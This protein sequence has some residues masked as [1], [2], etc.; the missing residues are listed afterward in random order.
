MELFKL[1]DTAFVLHNGKI[2]ESTIKKIK[3]EELYVGESDT[4]FKT[5][6]YQLK[7]VQEDSA[8]VTFDKDKVFKTR[9][10]LINSL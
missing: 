8:H 1:G 4:V 2:I 7:Y 3:T 6:E 10:D 9:E 5:V